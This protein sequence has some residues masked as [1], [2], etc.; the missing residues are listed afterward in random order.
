MLVVPLCLA[1]WAGVEWSYWGLTGRR[2]QYVNTGESK[3]REEGRAGREGRREEEVMFFPL[4]NL[5]AN[6]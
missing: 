2:H 5:F 3:E 6:A 1:A 4:F